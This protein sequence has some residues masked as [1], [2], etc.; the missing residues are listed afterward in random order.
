MV[1]AAPKVR[2]PEPAIEPPLQLSAEEMVMLPVPLM[3]PLEKVRLAMDWL[4][5]R[6]TVP[7]ETA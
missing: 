3:V 6:V 2:V 7:P 4:A 5:L 1:E